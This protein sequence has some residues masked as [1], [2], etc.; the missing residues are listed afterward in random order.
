MEM[1]W[2]LCLSELVFKKKPKLESIIS[3]DTGKLFAAKLYRLHFGKCL[4]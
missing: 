1:Q 4:I 2:V 3:P